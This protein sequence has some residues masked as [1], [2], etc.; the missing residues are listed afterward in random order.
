MKI[1]RSKKFNDPVANF[2]KS[3]NNYSRQ[4]TFIESRL[5][6][7]L[8]LKKIGRNVNVVDES[9][10]TYIRR[11]LLDQQPY[12]D[13]PQNFEFN[14]NKGTLSTVKL[15]YSSTSLACAY[16]DRSI[17]YS[18]ILDNPQLRMSYST[19]DLNE[20]NA[21]NEIMIEEN[22]QYVAVRYR[23]YICVG[24]APTYQDCLDEEFLVETVG[25]DKYERKMDIIA[26]TLNNDNL[27]LISA[28]NR[29]KRFD[30]DVNKEILSLNLS[31][32]FDEHYAHPIS[33][34]DQISSK[35]QT[36]L[37]TLTTRN[38]F[39]RLDCRNKRKVVLEKLFSSEN[40]VVNCE[41][42]MNHCQSLLSENLLYI[43]SSHMLYSFDFR[44]MK[45]PVVQWTHQLMKPPLLLKTS[46]Y[47]THEVICCSSHTT[48]DLKIFNNNRKAINFTSVKP[49][50][51]INT[52]ENLKEQGLFLLSDGIKDRIHASTTGVALH[53]EPN[54]SRLKLFTQNCFGDI[55]ESN[56]SCKN[57]KNENKNESSHAIDK[58]VL[59]E[60]ALKTD[61]NPNVEMTTEQ[62]LH[63]EEF[64]LDDIVRLQ[65]VSKIIKGEENN[66][67]NITEFDAE[68]NVE[69][70]VPQWKI[71]I[72]E[73]KAHNDLLAKEII[74]VWDDID[75]DEAPIEIFKE[76]ID[77]MQ[78]DREN[79]IDRISKWIDMIP[80]NDYQPEDTQQYLTCD[81][82]QEKIHDKQNIP[83]TM[84]STEN[85]KKEKKPR[86]TGF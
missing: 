78:E 3:Q 31:K 75:I 81:T 14:H 67:N 72:D 79:G 66:A 30:L 52:Y 55:F 37:I 1:A 83:I 48:G 40:C 12:N 45:L 71:S 86:V 49:H 32:Y 23:K 50:S 21:P 20:S 5:I 57:Y 53:C 10:R 43:V 33:L 65:C 16:D 28:D 9:M 7:Q 35:R 46:L 77:A 15:S 4:Q 27:T 42:L 76:A 44:N 80:E 29:L 56:L 8:K 2:T 85:M 73:A 74:I 60:K 11:K 69:S 84:S 54:H 59:W 26:S 38:N 22:A 25:F 51:I 47:R 58:F 82:N 36:N 18:K 68:N 41:K 6:S 34:H 17:H 13:E 70:A 24:K 19:E 39:C 64:I 63:S 62:R 61:C